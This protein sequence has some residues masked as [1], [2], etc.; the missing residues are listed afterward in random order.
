MKPGRADLQVRSTTVLDG[1]NAR[2]PGEISTKRAQ[3]T[4]TFSHSEIRIYPCS[5][6][7]AL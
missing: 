3:P 7:V 1:R 6:V 5:S 4:K 2:G